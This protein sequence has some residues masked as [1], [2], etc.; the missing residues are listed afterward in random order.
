M[1]ALVL[2]AAVVLALFAAMHLFVTWEH[3]RNPPG[4]PWSVLLPLV[5]AVAS[6]AVAARAFR[7]AFTDRRP[8]GTGGARPPRGAG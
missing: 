6:G 5:I 7:H 2:S 3:F 4:G 8:R 1:R